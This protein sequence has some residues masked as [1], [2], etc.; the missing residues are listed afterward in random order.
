V[1]R[2]NL[3]ADG[4]HRVTLLATQDT[5]GKN[6]PTI[7]GSTW[8]PWAQRLLFTSE[9]G[10]NGQ[11]ESQGGVWQA[12]LAVPSTLVNL[13]RFLGR[14]GFEGI[15]NDDRGSLYYVEDVGG[16]NIGATKA[17]RPNS[18]LYRFLPKDTSDLTKGGTIQALQVLLRGQPITFPDGGTGPNPA[19]YLALHTYGSPLKTTWIT[20][21]TTTSATAAPGP[22]DNALAKSLGAT[23]FKRPENGLFRPGSKF[24]EFYFDETGD[25]NSTTPAA[26]TGGFGSVFK[27]TQDPKS[28]DGSINLFYLGDETHAAFDNT[29][30]FSDTQIAFVEDAGDGLHSQR[31]GGQGALDSGWLFDVNVDYSNNPGK[32]IRF[33]AQ[34][35]DA[36]ATLDSSLSALYTTPAF[37]NDG[38]NEITGIH[39]SDGDAGKDGILGAKAPR[40]FRGDNAWRAF[41]TQQH[42]DNSTYELIRS[43][44]RGDD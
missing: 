23:P 35:R 11:G 2:I 41:Y 44:T 15:Q 24:K 18:F 25:T 4:P 43:A 20:L 39:V 10:P 21:T 5:D 8:D 14:G 29:A 16:A 31:N 33:L 34:G 22:D 7:D 37:Y 27:L 3:D 40:P 26:A 17:R 38:D 1:T 32:P 36:S 9:A 30:W 13:Q 19:Q 28:D 42:G 6:L 12:T